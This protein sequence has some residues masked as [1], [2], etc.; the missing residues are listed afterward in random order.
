MLLMP[1]LYFITLLEGFCL[2]SYLD[3]TIFSQ[4][5]AKR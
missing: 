2:T 5:V 3:I 1:F 4:K